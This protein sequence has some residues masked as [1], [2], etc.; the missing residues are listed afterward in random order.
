MPRVQETRPAWWLEPWLELLAV[1]AALAVFL[2]AVFGAAW[3][4]AGPR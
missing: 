1:M 2:A 4:A 3:L